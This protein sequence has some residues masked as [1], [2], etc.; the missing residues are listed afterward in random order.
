MIKKIPLSLAGLLVAGMTLSVIMCFAANEAY[1]QVRVLS[2]SFAVPSQTATKGISA[3]Q[4]S[5]AALFLAKQAAE[6]GFIDVSFEAV[7]RAVGDGPP[8]QSAGLGGLLS[9][10]PSPRSSRVIVSSNN[11]F[12]GSTSGTNGQ[13][14]TAKIL[15]ELDSIWEKQ[16]FDPVQCYQLWEELVFPPGR[17]NDAFTYSTS[18]TQN[19]FSYSINLDE[20]EPR[21]T[22]SGVHSLVKWAKKADRLKALKTTIEERGKLPGAQATANLIRIVLATVDDGMDRDQ[23]CTQLAQKAT[24]IVAGPESELMTSLAFELLQKTPRESEARKQLWAD[25]KSAASTNQRWATNRWMRHAVATEI[26][27]NAKA[28]DFAAFDSDAQFFLTIFDALTGNE[29]Y[30]AQ[31]KSSL[32]GRASSTALKEGFLEFGLECLKKQSQFSSSTVGIGN[33]IGKALLDPTGNQFAELLQKSPEERYSMFADLV[34]QMPR[35]GLVQ[36]ANVAPYERIPAEFVANYKSF[37]KVNKLP[38]EQVTGVESRCLSLIEWVMRDAIALGKKPELLE[39]I[40]ELEDRGSDDAVLAKAMLAKA[41]GRSIDLGDFT[42]EKNGELVLRSEITGERG[43]IMALD[44]EI[45]ETAAKD[46]SYREATFDFGKRLANRSFLNRSNDVKHGRY[47]EAIAELAMESP[48]ATSEQLQHFVVAEDF[49]MKDLLGNALGESMWLKNKDGAWEHRMGIAFSSLLLKYPL[50]GDYKITFDCLDNTYGESAFTFGGQYIDIRGYVQNIAV[51]TVGLR[52]GK[53]VPTSAIRRGGETNA[54]T[55][56]HDSENATYTV[57]IND[58]EVATF[59]L[60]EGAFPFV[61]PHSMHH[62]K[63]YLSNFKIEGNPTIPRELNLL[64]AN[65]IGWSNRFRY[66][67]LPPLPKIIAENAERDTSADH[68]QSDNT[69]VQEGSAVVDYDWEL[70]DAT[71][72]S[73]DHLALHQLDQE[74]GLT[75]KKRWHPP[76]EQWIYYLRPICD[77]ESVS[78][79]FYYEPGKYSLHPTIDRISLQID[80]PKLRKHWITSSAA[81]FGVSS[82]NGVDLARDEIINTPELKAK[83]WNRLAYSREGNQITVSVNDKPIYSQ[84]AD[85]ILRG[86]FGFLQD[87]E[88]FQVKVRNVILTGDWPESLPEDLFAELEAE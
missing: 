62:R 9:G 29:D 19:G 76:H 2:Q 70:K 79:E 1:A 64:D 78:C 39:R 75:T 85:K 27:Q 46:V 12:G 71:L 65:L 10:G 25:L 72:Q 17:P 40:R 34:F 18:E 88:A 52:T 5:Q 55:V 59:N 51:D 24:S 31:Q 63:M 38:I 37:H 68:K 35:F 43:P 22:Q 57:D 26:K 49:T 28:G 8:V 44:Y 82:T 60:D 30:V 69:D 14:N 13:T 80:R 53:Q 83:A 3:T 32:Y 16:E 20:P 45:F 54:V 7:R 15:Q 4:R 41:E 11:P 84:P 42:E 61:G 73:M 36:A 47:C 56:A 23:L 86:R 21:K 6:A 87:P 74:N 58:S 33:E 81:V 50:Q 66:R 77:G 48:P 67:A